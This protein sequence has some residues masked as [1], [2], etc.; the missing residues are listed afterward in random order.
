MT[1][2][3]A[4]WRAPVLR[5]SSEVGLEF[6]EVFFP[7]M[8]GVPLEGWFIPADSDKLIIH[9]HFPL[10]NRYGYP[11]HLPEFGGV[12]G[13]EV[14]FL[15]ASKARVDRRNDP[16]LQG[17]NYFGEHPEVAIDWFNSHSA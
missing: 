17:Y 1:G 2:R 9:N 12:G 6:E 7:S 3:T 8:D 10:G 14:N 11:E 15:P 16:A 5:R 4:G 13:F